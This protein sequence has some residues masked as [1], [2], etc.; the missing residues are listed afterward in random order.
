[1]KGNNVS[2]HQEQQELL[3]A[4]SKPTG[5]HCSFGREIGEL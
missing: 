5:A 2:D 4:A 3:Q 1:V